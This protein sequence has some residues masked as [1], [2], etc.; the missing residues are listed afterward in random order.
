MGIVR[1]TAYPS[2]YA[3][4]EWE[5]ENVPSGEQLAGG[6]FH[7]CFDIIKRGGRTQ[8]ERVQSNADGNVRRA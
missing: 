6:K 4:E 7:L 8:R 2:R 5:D 1:A 3:D